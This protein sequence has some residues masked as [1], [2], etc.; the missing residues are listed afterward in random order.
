MKL[1]TIW[2]VIWPERGPLFA[3]TGGIVSLL[4]DFTSF[5]AN[6]ANPNLLV[7]PLVALAGLLAWF[8]F[9]RVGAA[10]EPPE[11]TE[12]AVQCRECDAF[13]VMLFAS[14][15][16][17]LLLMAGQGETATERFGRQLGVIQEQ[18]ADIAEDTTAIRDVTS[19]AELVRSPRSAADFYRNAWIHSMVRR[20]AD[21]AWASIQELYR[22]HTPNKLDAAELY[23][24]TGRTH[25][26][27][28]QLLAQMVD[29]GRSRR[30][31]AMLV[32]AGRNMDSNDDAFRLYE[33]A[34]AIDADMPF[35][36]W[37]VARVQLMQIS[38]GASAQENLATARA[39]VVGHERFLEV[40]SRKP[41]AS[42]FYLPQHQADFETLARSQLDS[43]RQ[44]AATWERIVQQQQEMEARRRR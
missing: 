4:S 5:L 43:F 27:R 7:W 20:D 24:S 6:I 11:K 26:T 39:T 29:V 3:V 30:D 18:V 40:A 36:Y 2:R 9:G 31:A 25:L 19:S 13:R 1:A 37:D 32:I 14:A 8:C 38:G 10:K 34:R 41:V 42:Y 44:N 16:V 23:F 33:E 21:Q 28:D 15:G 22:R 35:A 12:E 17:A